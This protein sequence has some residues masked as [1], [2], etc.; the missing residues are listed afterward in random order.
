MRAAAWRLQPPGSPG[1]AQAWPLPCRA[2]S[3]QLEKRH[4]AFGDVTQGDLAD[5]TQQLLLKFLT[6]FRVAPY[7]Q[8]TRR[9]STFSRRQ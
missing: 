7:S 4:P 2:H 1:Q 3:V 9:C 5:W 8:Q 6:I